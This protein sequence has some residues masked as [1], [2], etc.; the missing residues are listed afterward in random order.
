MHNQITRGLL[1]NVRVRQDAVI[2]CRWAVAGIRKKPALKV[3]SGVSCLSPPNVPNVIV[4]QYHHHHE[5]EILVSYRHTR[6]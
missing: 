6:L 3:N 2:T 5:N 4:V 1:V